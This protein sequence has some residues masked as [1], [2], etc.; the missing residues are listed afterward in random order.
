VH[1][2]TLFNRIVGKGD[3]VMYSAL[4][5]TFIVLSLSILMAH[6]MDAFWSRP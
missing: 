3:G 2:R 5:A 6:A 1:A 4:A